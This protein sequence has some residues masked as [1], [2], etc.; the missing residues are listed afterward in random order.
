[1]RYAEHVPGSGTFE[2]SGTTGAG[3]RTLDR[4]A[5]AARE[6]RFWVLHLEADAA[7]W[8]LRELDDTP[9]AY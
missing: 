4:L 9:A 8:T 6:Q 1:M 3:F 2:P 7:S 5:R